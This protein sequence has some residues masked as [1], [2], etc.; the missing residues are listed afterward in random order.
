MEMMTGAGKM[1]QFVILCFLS[2]FP[3]ASEL[4]EVKDYVLLTVKSS[5]STP[6]VGE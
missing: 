4:L 5:A 3:V 1:K 2:V 6:V